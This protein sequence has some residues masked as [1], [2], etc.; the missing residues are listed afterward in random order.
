M[1]RK[2]KK[3]EING[4]SYDV[5]EDTKIP[6]KTIKSTMNVPHIYFNGIMAKTG[7]FYKCECGEIF[8]CEHIIQNSDIDTTL[9]STISNYCPICGNNRIK[10]LDQE[11]FNKEFDIS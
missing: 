11:E 2:Y 9:V 10:H 4:T 8:M 3:I 7:R 5:G 6:I 1:G